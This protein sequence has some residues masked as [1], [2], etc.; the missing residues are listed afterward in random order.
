MSYYPVLLIDDLRD[1]KPELVP[2]DLTVMRTATDALEILQRKW[3]QIWLDHDL[4]IDSDGNDLTIMPVVDRMC[5]LAD[6]G[7]PINV[8]VVLIHTSNPYGAS[9]IQKSLERYGYKTIR[10]NAPE[11]FHVS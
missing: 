3:G 8:E 4:G 1:F 7:S 11:F 10:V 9:M 2:D 6:G 5:E